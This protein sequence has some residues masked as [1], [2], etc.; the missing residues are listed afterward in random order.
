[1][2]HTLDAVRML[3]TEV[4]AE[5]STAEIAVW[6]IT[7][8]AV[9]YIGTLALDRRYRNRDGRG[10]SVVLGSG[11][12]RVTMLLAVF[13]LLAVQ[14]HFAG[15][16]TGADAPTLDWFVQ[17]RSPGWTTA[18]TYVT[19]AG[20]PVA[21]VVVAVVSAVVL[22][23]RS[24]SL[25]PGAVLVGTVGAAAAASTVVKTV[26]ERPRPAPATQL[27]TE[28]DFSFPSGHVTGT[29][30]LVGALVVVLGAG[31]R[32][33]IRSV[34]ACAAGVFAA[35]VAVTRMYLGVHYLTDVFGGALLG[36]AAVVAGSIV[37]TTLAKR[38][39]PAGGDDGVPVRVGEAVSPTAA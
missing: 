19:K 9:V 12:T 36:T 2:S 21:T 6:T 25:L 37:A 38:R 26:V 28:T 22:S 13:A 14:V 15:W 39:T 16:L 33:L 5:E 29:V 23:M 31:H 17:H 18:A 4:H 34:M 32:P 11:V 1:M 3:V 20:G 8:A 30:A 27:L 7:V 10:S 35:T 24:R